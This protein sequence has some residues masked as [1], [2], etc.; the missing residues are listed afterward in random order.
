MKRAIAIV[1]LLTALTACSTT[2]PG[3]PVAEPPQT[4]S[5]TNRSTADGDG[6]DKERALVALDP[7]ELITPEVHAEFGVDSDANFQEFPSSRS[8][9]W[10]GTPPGM[11]GRFAFG[12]AI[13]AKLGVD[14]VVSRNEKK[15]ITIN[16]RRAVTS[17][18][19]A[20]DVYAISLEVT[21]T[22]R[23]DVQFNGG[24]GRNPVEQMWERATRLAELV[25]P[26]LP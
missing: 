25:E 9:K 20:G 19:G 7:C 12:Y 3:A 14:E 17:I 26:K 6:T 24:A 11:T 10:N 23:L 21:P 15:E 16:G 22:A 18:R 4:G 8:C 2:T 5:E 1:A 13:F